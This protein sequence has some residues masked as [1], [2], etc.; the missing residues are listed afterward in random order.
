MAGVVRVVWVP[1]SDRLRGV[2][3]CGAEHLAEG[4]VQVWEWLLAHPVGHGDEVPA[5][6]ELVGARA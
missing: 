3:H 1:G 5:A 6:P 4:P 2:C